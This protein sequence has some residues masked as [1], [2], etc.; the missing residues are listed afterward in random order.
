MTLKQ[1]SFFAVHMVAGFLNL[2]LGYAYVKASLVNELES[3]VPLSA[4]LEAGFLLTG[5]V[6]GNLGWDALKEVRQAT[7]WSHVIYQVARS[8]APLVIWLPLFLIAVDAY[9]FGITTVFRTEQLVLL[10]VSFGVGVLVNS[11]FM[12]HGNQHKNA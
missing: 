9:K 11:Y 8:T 7:N 10:A 3:S 5:V 6:W 12:W 2:W 1:W 4:L